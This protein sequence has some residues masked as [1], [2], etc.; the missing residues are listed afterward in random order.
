MSLV[1]PEI[2]AY[3]EAHS[4]LPSEVCEEIF[5]YTKKNVPMPQMLSG[6]LVGSFLGW[7][8]RSIGAK[9]VLEIG[10]YTG[11]SALYM[12][13]RLPADGEVI[14]LDINPE[15]AA[16]AQKFWDKSPHGKKIKSVLGSASDSMGSLSGTFD[17]IFID[18]DK[19]G[20]PAYLHRALLLL[21]PKGVIVA[22][23]CLQAGRVLDKN[24]KEE[25]VHAIQTFNEKI[26]KD[27]HLE[28]MLLPLR[29]GLH[30]IRRR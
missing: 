27:P 25:S 17:F 26:K 3:C 5:E 14:T 22:D 29:D 19:T 24:S 13:E 28:H 4:E 12:A 10:T 7:V 1:G 8:I 6:P 16:I 20:Y 18:A 23:N 2:E 30:L 21:S 15:T 11:Y 9:R